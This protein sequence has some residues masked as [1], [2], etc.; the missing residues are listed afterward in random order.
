MEINNT[1]N[2]NKEALDTS[3]DDELIQVRAIISCPNG[4]YKKKFRNQ[5]L[6]RNLDLLIPSLKIFDWMTC[7]KCGELLRLDLEFNI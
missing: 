5:V 7:T 6:R 4:D 1:Q 3:A 2:N